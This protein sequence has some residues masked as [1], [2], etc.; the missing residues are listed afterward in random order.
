MSAGIVIVILAHP[1]RTIRTTGTTISVGGGTRARTNG[2]MRGGLDIARDRPLLVGSAMTGIGDE[3][4]MCRPGGE[5]TTVLG[6]T[7]R[8]GGVVTSGTS[9]VYHHRV[10]TLPPTVT[11][12]MA[13]TTKI[14]NQISS[15]ISTTPPARP[16]WTS[17]TAPPPL[18]L[19]SINPLPP[20]PI[21]KRRV[22]NNSARPD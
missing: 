14:S 12:A 22:W 13:P 19:P 6:E 2:R 9:R 11:A 17:R 10:T 20:P 3:A 21:P 7:A 4:G 1:S 8:V 15:P 16:P 5:G 18:A